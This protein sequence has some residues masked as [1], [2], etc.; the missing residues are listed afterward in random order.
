[1]T[2]WQEFLKRKKVATRNSKIICFVKKL[3]N[4]MEQ[5]YPVYLTLSLKSVGADTTSNRRLE[6]PPF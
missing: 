4:R 2:V 6:G 1:M 5:F 3:K